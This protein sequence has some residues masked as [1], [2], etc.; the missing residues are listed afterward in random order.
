[1]VRNSSDGPSKRPR[2]DGCRDLAEDND[3]RKRVEELEEEYK[4]MKEVEGENKELREAME[5]LRGMV[6]CPVC[7]L[8]TRQVG[9]VPVCSNGHFVCGTCRDRIR[10][11]TLVGEPKCPSCMV[12]LGNATSLLASRVIEKLKHECEHEGCDEMIPFADLEKHQ[13]VCLFR[14]VLCPGIHDCN[15]E[16]SFNM[17]E[18][19]VKTC[20]D[21]VKPAKHNSYSRSHELSTKK[22]PTIEDIDGQWKTEQIM[23]FGKSFFA[24][25][26]IENRSH[27]SEV[28]MLGSE[29]E[30]RGFLVSMTILDEEERVFTTKICRPRPISL[31]R[32]GH[33]ELV[34]PEK[35]LASICW[36]DGKDFIYRSMI[37]VKKLKYL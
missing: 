31:E 15:L 21:I 25:Y 4:R 20:D 26:K 1:M 3:I 35:A 30:C 6:E 28:I 10:Q 37:S 8:V 19:H 9:P 32:W 14:N 17:V 7:L 27:F 33:M 13:L 29:A 36:A 34:V 22:D 11:E 5:E 24:R 12:A 23:A 18:E 2:T 16:I